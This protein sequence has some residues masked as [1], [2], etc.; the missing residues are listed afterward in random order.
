MASE[1]ENKDYAESEKD[2]RRFYIQFFK[3][4][5]V[6]FIF[7]YLG[8]SSIN[9]RIDGALIV[10]ELVSGKNLSA[11]ILPPPNY[12]VDSW[13]AV[14]ELREAIGSKDK[15]ER[16]AARLDNSYKKEFYDR[17]DH[18]THN[19]AHIT[20]D[21]EVR[22]E[23]FDRSFKSAD[24]FFRII[25]RE[26][27]PAVRQGDRAE[28][29]RLLR[30]KLAPLFED[31][32]RHIDNTVR[33]VTSKNAQ[34]E[35][36]L[37]E[38]QSK[39]QILQYTTIVL[40][41]VLIILV[42]V[43]LYR[44]F[45]IVRSLNADLQR[46]NSRLEQ[47]SIID[48]LTGL[49]NRRYFEMRIESD[50][51]RAVRNGSP[52]EELLGFFMADIDHFKQVNDSYGH[53]A[54]DQVLTIFASRVKKAMRMEDAAFRWGGEEFL[55]LIQDT[56][57]HGAR[58]FANRLVEIIRGKVFCVEDL[59]LNITCSIGYCLFPV[60]GEGIETS[61]WKDCVNLAD[62]ALYE[63]KHTGRN[64]VIAVETVK[65]AYD[66]IERILIRQDPAEAVRQGLITLERTDI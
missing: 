58:E 22:R 31:H 61:T 48:N 19:S 10:E 60:P 24:A 28:A 46:L 20:A 26:Y 27:L 15:V 49:Y 56:N 21:T 45:R 63:A 8:V 18:W 17:Y 66:A 3:A 23:L 35:R 29:D 57:R 30:N 25:D 36:Q 51:S 5:L 40:T 52:P 1:S 16:I 42:A 4:A 43:T 13:A 9:S 55:F 2:R 32:R 41:A 34:M 6:L 62:F 7:I 12:V 38:I 11:D 44:R 59:N 33:M 47:M 65:S 53:L 37:S 64:R 50:I 54:G 14:F 39:Q